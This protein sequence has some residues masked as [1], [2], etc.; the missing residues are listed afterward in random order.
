MW[1]QGGYNIYN[2]EGFLKFVLYIPMALIPDTNDF[3]IRMQKNSDIWDIWRFPK[4][5]VTPNHLFIDW[6]FHDKP[7]ILGYPHFCNHPYWKVGKD[8][9]KWLS[10][11]ETQVSTLRSFLD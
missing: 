1:K 6:I 10:R 11:C 3:N 9:T 7:S 8:L 4:I 5:W 2:W